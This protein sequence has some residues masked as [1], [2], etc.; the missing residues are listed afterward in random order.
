M[1][2][3]AIDFETANEKRNSACSLGL[4]VIKNNK[5]I[6]KRY[7][8]IRPCEFRFSSTNIWIHGIVPEDVEN[9]PRFSKVWEEVKPYIE[10][11]LVVAHNASFDMSVLRKTLDFYNIE[12]PKCIYACTLI[13][14]R[15]HN[16][17]LHNHK[18][19]TIYKDMKKEFNHHHAMDDAIAC[20]YIFMNICERLNINTIDDLNTKGKI[21]LGTLDNNS[22]K[23]AS[24]LIR[25]EKKFFEE[26][27]VP[28]NVNSDYFKDKVVV[29]T[30]ALGK[31]TRGEAMSK[32]R[33]LGGSTGS[34][35]T[36]KTD[37]LVVAMKSIDRLSYS[38]KSNK[39]R[40]AEALIK[41]GE[42]I[43]LLSEEEFLDLI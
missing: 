24:A 19:N 37:I 27:I 33:M 43:K 9:K 29:F 14:S 35:V 23:A 30:G 39:L 7:W 41:Q 2:F 17:H 25:Y 3:V 40:K 15:I 4:V 20:A 13:L 11:N 38:N 10:N 1:D 16:S 32:V 34:S 28:V 42:K 31:M 22:Y 18:L 8:L 12:Y 21:K 36:K 5:I 6:E 26:E